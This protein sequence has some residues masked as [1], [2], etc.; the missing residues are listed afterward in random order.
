MEQNLENFKGKK[1]Q[2]I[3]LSRFGVI[4]IFKNSDQNHLKSKY[5]P[6]Y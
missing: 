2:K 6:K 1:S 3:I 5:L 4:S